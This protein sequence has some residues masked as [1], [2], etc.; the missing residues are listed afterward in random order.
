MSSEN[1]HIILTAQGSGSA[2]ILSMVAIICAK[3]KCHI[4]ESKVH[5]FG[6]DT[7]IIMLISGSWHAI[8][9]LEA[10]LPTIEKKTNFVFHCKRT[11]HVANNIGLPYQAQLIATDRVGILAEICSFFDKNGIIVDE[12]QAQTYSPTSSQTQMCQLQLNIR[13][14]VKAHL[15]T[16]REAFMTY[17]EELNL[18]ALLEP[19]K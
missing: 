10:K 1:H 8:A 13:I 17:C 6:E 19:I 7:A 11:K 16:I 15:A 2:N 18:D 14:P 12:C 9:K 3:Q 5:N 4:L